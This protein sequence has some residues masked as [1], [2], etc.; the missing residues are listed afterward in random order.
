MRLDRAGNPLTAD[1]IR[2]FGDGI[3]DIG[4]DW[5]NLLPPDTDSDGL[6]WP[7]ISSLYA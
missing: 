3:T 4:T 6:A 7:W 2:W 1:N 5:L